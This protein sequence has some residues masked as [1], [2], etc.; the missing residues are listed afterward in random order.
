MIKI[1]TEEEIKSLRIEKVYNIFSYVRICVNSLYNS[2]PDR[3]STY[4]D[5]KEAEDLENY[6]ELL[7]AE[8]KRRP[9]KKLTKQEKLVQRKQ[10]IAGLKGNR[11][12]R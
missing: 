8:L 11:R 6:L 2:D 3:D 5:Y 12:A 10:R 4:D 1:L 7:R 9:F